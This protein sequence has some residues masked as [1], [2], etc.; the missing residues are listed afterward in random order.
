M[1]NLIVFIVFI[2]SRF[3]ATRLEIHLYYVLFILYIL[4]T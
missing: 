4:Q 2:L 1:F 3:H